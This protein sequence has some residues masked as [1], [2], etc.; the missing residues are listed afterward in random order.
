MGTPIAM[1]PKKK[2]VIDSFHRWVDTFTTFMLV[3]VNS[4]PGRAAELITYL[5]IIN[6]AETNLEGSPGTTIMNNSPVASP[7]IFVSI[8]V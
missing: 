3:M 4:Y 8:G 2:P 7:T 6:H 5:Q 1:V